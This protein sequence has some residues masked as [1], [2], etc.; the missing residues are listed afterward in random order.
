[1]RPIKK[2]MLFVVIFVFSMAIL[3]KVTSYSSA[4]IESPVTLTIT[5]N[6]N[7]LISPQEFSWEVKQGES[8]IG[9]FCIV[10]NLAEDIEVEVWFDPSDKYVTIADIEEEYVKSGE[11]ALLHVEISADAAAAPG[12]VGVD[13]IF[14]AKWRGGGAEIKTTGELEIVEN[15]ELLLLEEQQMLQLI[16][17]LSSDLEKEP[18]PNLPEIVIEDLNS[19]ES[20]STEQNN[21]EP[22]E[23]VAPKDSS[24]ADST[25]QD[26]ESENKQSSDELLDVKKDETESGQ[27]DVTESEKNQTSGLDASETGSQ[28]TDNPEN[29]TK[30]TSRE[31]QTTQSQTEK[32]SEVGKNKTQNTE[33]N[34]AENDVSQEESKESGVEDTQ[35]KGEVAQE[36]TEN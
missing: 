4:T 35:E 22:N 26:P 27:Q 13:V 10:N 33:T 17:E 9:N 21:L 19:R 11:S 8:T 30:E 18:E 36:I 24:P 16:P 7:A 28:T 14:Y 25:P 2:M 34:S 1:M 20:M 15:P 31:T 32:D 12:V 3:N 5:D 6:G 29:V 23:G